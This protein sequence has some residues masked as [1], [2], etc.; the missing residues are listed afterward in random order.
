MKNLLYFLV[1][2][3]LFVLSQNT[4]HEATISISELNNEL[5]V[6]AENG[7]DYILENT[8][9]TYDSIIDLKYK[10][11]NRFLIHSL[12]ITLLPSCQ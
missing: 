3:P 8:T 1:L 5:K 4:R 11:D 12:Q 7:Q 9:I 10:S 2:I 6:A